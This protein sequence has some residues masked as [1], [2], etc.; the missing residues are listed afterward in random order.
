MRQ[1]KQL[2]MNAHPYRNMPRQCIKLCSTAAAVHRAC[3]KKLLD[4]PC[5]RQSKALWPHD[6]SLSPHPLPLLR[7]ASGSKHICIST[8]TAVPCMPY[9]GDCSDRIQALCMFDMPAVAF[10][11]LWSW[12]RGRCLPHVLAH[13]HSPAGTARLHASWRAPAPP[14]PGACMARTSQPKSRPRSVS[15]QPAPAHG[16]VQQRQHGPPEVWGVLR[17]QQ[18][19]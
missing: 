14:H 10:R 7:P 8:A 19:C 4:A 11:H 9:D 1:P 6:T 2:T 12:R 13:A 16:E 18:R 5:R 15:K 3:I 17:F